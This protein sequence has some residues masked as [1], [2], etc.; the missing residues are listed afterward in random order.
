MELEPGGVRG[1]SWDVWQTAGLGD[2]GVRQVW[3]TY[4]RDTGRVTAFITFTE[5]RPMVAVME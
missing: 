4:P 3:G 1:G 5:T 2:T